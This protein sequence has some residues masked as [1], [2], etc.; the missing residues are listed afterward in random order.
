M[1]V[2]KP[3]ASPFWHYDFVIAGTRFHGS[4]GTTSRRAAEAVE[5]RLRT[6]AA[7]SATRRKPALTLDHAAARYWN[8]VAKHQASAKTTEYQL[9]NLC[10]GIGA[11]TYLH[12]IAAPVLT[13]Y[14]SKRRSKVSDASTNRE[15]EL[16]RR[17]LRRADRAWRVDVG[18][19]IDWKAILLHEPEGRVRELTQAEEARLFQ[20]L[21]QD[22]HPLIRFAIMTGVRLQNAIALTWPQVDFDAGVI[23]LMT[24][25]RK[26]GGEIHLIPL[27]PDLVAL[28][29]AERGRH[30]TR[31]FTYEVARGRGERK[32]STRRPFT[33]T[34]WRKAWSR[35]LTQAGIADFRFHDLR[36]TAATRTLRASQNLKVVQTLLGHK[37][38]ATTSRYAHAMLDD[39][40]AAMA[41][42]ISRNSPEAIKAKSTKSLKNKT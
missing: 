22:L 9:A 27:V 3:K 24:K 40:A 23:R 5:A 16:L 4:A 8:E 39:V 28:L 32:R 37:D 34:G 41:A 21:R 6:E 18:E 29:S 38:I 10:A 42:T 36:H 11:D 33:L 2:Y 13:T 15:I 12:D 30:P 19:P 20:H 35:A 14:V 17:L 25:S 7:S 26:P 1:S 31:V